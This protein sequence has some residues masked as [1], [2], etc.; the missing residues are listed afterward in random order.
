[1]LAVANHQ[2][3]SGWVVMPKNFELYAG[4]YC[5]TLVLI[6]ALPARPLFAV[7]ISL[8]ILIALVAFAYRTFQ[9]NDQLNR[10]LE[11]ND[12]LL[13]ALRS[14]SPHVAIN[15][16]KLASYASMMFPRQPLTT[17]AYEKTYRNVVAQYFPDYLC[18]KQE[19]LKTSRW[20][21]E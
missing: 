9:Y 17:F 7:G 13:A 18:A 14:D 11:F 6:L 20:T 19:V 1:P 5:V 4:L 10:Q 21:E 15:H 12:K 3:I 2:L 16:P 8:L